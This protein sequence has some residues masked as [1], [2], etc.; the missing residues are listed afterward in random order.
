M[1][2]C[3]MCGEVLTE[4]ELKDNGNSDQ[5]EGYCYDCWSASYEQYYAE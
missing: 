1:V 5:T 4:Q 3:F 2:K